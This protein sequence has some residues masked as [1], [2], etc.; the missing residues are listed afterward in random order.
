MSTNDGLWYVK[1]PDG[2]VARMTLDQIDEAFNAGRIDENVMCLPADGS[3]W[4]RLGELAGLEGS[5]SSGFAPLPS[6]LR[7]VSMNATDEIATP[8]GRRKSRMPVVFGALVA[9]IAVVGG[10]MAL[11]NSG[12]FRSS[13]PPIVLSSPPAPVTTT[14]EPVAAPAPPPPAPSPVV[15]ATAA[16]A[17]DTAVAASSADGA[18]GKA[19]KGKQDKSKAHKK[20][21]AH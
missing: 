5:N 4:A 2:D 10:G 6:S 15:A 1:T 19:T 17:A 21:G 3:R 9:V 8:F 11:K 16:P 14:A 18:K 13:S 20:K 7:P 12:V